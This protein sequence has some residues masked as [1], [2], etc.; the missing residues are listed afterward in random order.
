[1]ATAP[2]FQKAV[3]P[4]T[5]GF[6]KSPE[7]ASFGYK[8][9]LLPASTNQVNSPYFGASI[10][11]EASSAAMDKAYEAFKARTTGGV[12]PVLTAEIAKDLLYRSMTTG[13]PTV[14]LNLYGGAGAVKSVAAAAGLDRTPAD[15]QKYEIENNLPESAAT[16][17]NKQFIG[18]E[19][20]VLLDQ[21]ETDLNSSD[22]ATAKLARDKLT[23]QQKAAEQEVVAERTAAVQAEREAAVIAD[24]DANG[25][26]FSTYGFGL[27]D[28]GDIADTDANGN[29][30]SPFGFGLGDIGDNPTTGGGLLSVPTGTTAATTTGTGTTTEARQF[31]CV[32]VSTKLS[33]PIGNLLSVWRPA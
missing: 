26:K 32:N 12:T 11:S 16:K 29:K 13:V 19:G 2:G 33:C 18:P 4:V 20:A 17:L 3:T 9:R 22:A 28:I 30:F 6:Y 14:E 31:F 8:D 10:R 5:E 25:N 27:G 23:A 7:F 21:L 15:I 1:M 24:T